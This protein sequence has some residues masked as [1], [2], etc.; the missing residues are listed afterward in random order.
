MRYAEISYTYIT[1]TAEA[2]LIDIGEETFWIPKSVIRYSDEVNFEIED[3]MEIQEWFAL[4]EEI[5]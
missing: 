1:E 3:E 2:V 5:I 4:Q